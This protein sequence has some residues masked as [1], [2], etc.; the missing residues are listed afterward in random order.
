[1]TKT[2]LPS[3]V[4]ARPCGFA[5]TSVMVSMTRSRL[6]LITETVSDDWLA[7]IQPPA[8][9]RQRAAERLGAHLDGVD[10]LPCVRVLI[11]DTVPLAMFVT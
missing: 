5:P 7:T 3:A 1:M 11:T 9:G 8:V 10:D 4:M 6:V 2:C